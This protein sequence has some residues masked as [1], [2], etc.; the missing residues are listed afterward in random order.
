MV[1]IVTFTL[2]LFVERLDDDDD[3]LSLI[4]WPIIIIDWL[5]MRTYA[6]LYADLSLIFL[7][8]IHDDGDDDDLCL[9]FYP[10]VIL[11]ILIAQPEPYI[12]VESLHHPDDDNDAI[13]QDLP[14]WDRW[15]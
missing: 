4:F 13:C 7:A 9:I 12:V 15:A 1:K 5:M 2:W 6:R 10:S 8:E 11:I 3:D 14:H